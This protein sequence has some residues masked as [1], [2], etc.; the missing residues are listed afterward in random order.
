MLSFNLSVDTSNMLYFFP[1]LLF[2][3]LRL[4][5]SLKNHPH[6][7]N[8]ISSFTHFAKVLVIKII[9]LSGGMEPYHFEESFDLGEAHEFSLDCRIGG[10]DCPEFGLVGIGGNTN[11]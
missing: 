4:S 5:P 6:I 10:F 8:F 7:F 2:L 9:V 11:K 1:L 3:N